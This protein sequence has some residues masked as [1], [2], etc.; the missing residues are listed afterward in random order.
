MDYRVNSEQLSVIVPHSLLFDRRHRFVL[1]IF[2]HE[3]EINLRSIHRLSCAYTG[4]VAHVPHNVFTHLLLSRL[5]G[6]PYLNISPTSREPSISR[7]YRRLSQVL[8][9]WYDCASTF[10]PPDMAINVSLKEVVRPIT[11]PP[12]EDGDQTCGYPP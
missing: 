11:C 9:S 4:H 10:W 3:E 1:R 2:L 7:R 6:H 5:F 8:L 12:E